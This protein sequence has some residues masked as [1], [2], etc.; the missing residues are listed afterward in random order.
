MTERIGAIAARKRRYG[1]RRVYLRLRREAWK[2]NRKRV[3]RLYREAG[4][5]VP[6]RQRKRI[7]LVDRKPLPKPVA[8]NLS[9]SKDFVSNSLADGRR[10]R[11]LN[12]LDDCTRECV[13]IEGKRS[14][15]RVLPLVT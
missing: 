7:A 11:C 4:L 8:A 9:W 13:T 6:R 1:Y 12:I 14:I 10:L 5:A 2:V 3:Y 15:D